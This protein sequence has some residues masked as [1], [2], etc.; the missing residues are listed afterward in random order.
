MTPLPLPSHQ[1]INQ[2]LSFK[3]AMHV[4]KLVM[5]RLENGLLCWLLSIVW[6]VTTQLGRST[7]N[8]RRPSWTS[9]SVH[10]RRWPTPQ[11]GRKCF[12]SYDWNKSAAIHSTTTW[13]FFMI[14]NLKCWIGPHLSSISW[15][16]TWLWRWQLDL[17]VEIKQFDWK[18]GGNKIIELKFSHAVRRGNAI[19][20]S[21]LDFAPVDF[22]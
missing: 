14:L 22:Y 7:S 16:V 13:P 3:R 11:F 2:S 19:G 18:Y 1:C 5:E 15:R 21:N 6:L 4:Q 8:R 20:I 12:S 17:K 9:F 10:D